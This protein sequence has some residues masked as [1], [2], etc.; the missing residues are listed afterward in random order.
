MPASPPPGWYPD[1]VDPRGWRWWDGRAWTPYATGPA[2]TAPSPYGQPQGHAY[3][4]VDARRW[5]DAA[6]KGE[7]TMEPWARAATVVYSTAA[8]AAAFVFLA[9]AS[10]WRAYFHSLRVSFDSIGAT[11]QPPHVVQ[12]ALW[13]DATV[14]FAL[15][16]E[17]VFLVWQHRAATT[18][19]R[20]GYPARRSPGLGVGSYF[21]PVVNVWFPYQAL[22]DCLPPT[23]A[24]R[25]L[26]LVVWLLLVLTPFVEIPM[27]TLLAEVPALGDAFLAVYVLLEMGLAAGG[28]RM[29]GAI[30]SAHRRALASS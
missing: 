30:T 14:P 29:V 26:V 9:T 20:L 15:A 4:G 27:V 22:R 8:I 21:I 1:P 3:P 10:A 23:S 11:A 17:V 18:A 28:Y 19:Q 7:A 25:R 16:A 13:A 6:Y 12:P 24:D 5:A 2:S